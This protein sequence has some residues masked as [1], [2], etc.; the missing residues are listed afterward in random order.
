MDKL[1]ILTFWEIIK[2]KNYALLDIDYSENKIY[3]ESEIAQ[4]N[5]LWS[6]LEDEYYNL[7]KDSKSYSTIVKSNDAFRLLLKIE[8][9]ENNLNSLVELYNNIEIIDQDDFIRIK[10]KIY[11]NF[12]LI[13]DRITPKYF[14]GLKENFNLITRF[15][16]AFKSDY[17]INYKVVTDEIKEEVTNIYNIV[18]SVG[19][20]LGYQINVKQVNVMEWIAY[21]EIA[22]QKINAQKEAYN[23]K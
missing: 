16:N 19:S 4:F 5:L 8:L 22:K 18:A 15:I 3:T 20:I 14:D 10:Q 2:S 6:K 9:L 1:L 12:T 23:G 7:K 11:Q 17:E 21:E 13:H